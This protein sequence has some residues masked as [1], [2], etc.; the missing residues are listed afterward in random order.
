[1]STTFDLKKFRIEKLKNKEGK[2]LTQNELSIMMGESQDQVSR[3]ESKP[4]S[5]NMTTFFKICNAVGMMPEQVLCGGFKITD[6]KPLDFGNPYIERD[7]RKDLFTKYCEPFLKDNKNNPSEIVNY[8]TLLK[9]LD[10]LN[11][12]MD[13]RPFV[14]VVGMSDSGKTRLI[15]ALTGIEGLVTSW[16]PTTSITVAFIH[17]ASKPGF[18]EDKDVIIFKGD[19]KDF[20]NNFDFHNYRTE[21]Y[22]KS[23]EIKRGGFDLLEKYGTHQSKRNEDENAHSAL[24]FVDSPFLKSCNLIDF[25]GYG[26]SLGEVD[27]KKFLSAIN[28]SDFFIFLSTA[29][30]FMNEQDFI[31]LKYSYEE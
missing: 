28:I 2:P 1:M 6:P 18:L 13:Y 21:E 17:K 5:I 31:Q 19:K 7:I 16:T 14:A 4:E 24:V 3:W 20:R 9:E 22:Y 23:W 10:E 29:N 26:S 27:N 25:P 12:N 8:Q 15:Q 11:M 30:S